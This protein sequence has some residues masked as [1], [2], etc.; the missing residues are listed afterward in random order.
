[1]KETKIWKNFIYNF[2][3]KILTLILPFVL[4]PYLS[5]VVGAEGV[6]IYSYQVAISTYFIMFAKLGIL[7][8]GVRN[9]AMIKEKPEQLSIFFSELLQQQIL[10]SA[11]AFVGYFLYIFIFAQKYMDIA[12]ALGIS[13]AS[14]VFDINW[15]Y[16]GLEQF[17]KIVIRNSIIKIVTVVGVLIFVKSKEDLWKYALIYSIDI[18]IGNLS[19]WIGIRRYVRIKRC[20]A[21]HT[22][23]HLK[24]CLVL[25]VPIL[26]MSIYQL[27]DKIMLG[28]MST[29]EETGIYA[30]GEKLILSLL[31]FIPMLGTIMLPRMSKLFSDGET[32]KGQQYIAYSM[33]FMMFFACALAFG[34]AG[35]AEEF[36]PLFYGAGFEG[37]VPV[38]H[39]LSV[40]IVLV[41]W[42]GVIRSQYIIPM[43]KDRIFVITVCSGAVVNLVINIL[44]IPHMGAM[45]AVWGTVLAEISVAVVQLFFVRGALPLLNYLRA[46]VI[47]F[48]AG[49][50]ML[51]MIRKLAGILHGSMLSGVIYEVL[52][53][54][55]I[56]L[57]ICMIY[58]SA[59]HKVFIN[60][61]LKQYVG[62]RKNG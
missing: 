5:R 41:A 55:G 33:Q 61:I 22:L 10:T 27:M 1:M 42:T 45:G 20:S 53:G 16:N 32:Q 49:G 13:V 48:F 9:V 15:F 28:M 57:L 21:I 39:M 36:V 34:I 54:G 25:F 29:M 40:I 3:Y 2:S 17:K 14:A 51:V 62:H 60:N 19:F 8:Y 6:G 59:R 23:K 50:I 47:Y 12:M 31:E 35:I 37:A 24:P 4:A 7:N 11:I 38:V 18:L 43:A 44:L 46:A 26:A 56:Y 58:H 30:N 52:C